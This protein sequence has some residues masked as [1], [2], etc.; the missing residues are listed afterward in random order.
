MALITIGWEQSLVVDRLGMA[1]S[2]FHRRAGERVAHVAVSASYVNMSASEL[3]IRQ[4]MIESRINPVVWRVALGT[5]CAKASLVGVIRCVAGN[6]F[7]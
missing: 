6:A 4:G 7:T 5:D 3:E 1:G 2:T